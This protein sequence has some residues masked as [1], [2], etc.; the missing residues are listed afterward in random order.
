[1]TVTPTLHLMV[2]LPGVGKTTLASTI[3]EQS[4]ALRLTPDEWMQPLF[5]D[6]EA[7]GKRDVLEG[8][9]IWVAHRTLCGGLSV[10]LDFGFWSPEERYALRDIADRAGAQF[11]LHY[12][13]LS[14]EQRRSRAED[15]WRRG[16]TATFEMTAEDHDRFAEVFA[17]PTV[18]ELR[19]HTMP[20]PP[21]PFSS[22]PAWASWRWPSLPRVD[23]SQ[24]TEHVAVDGSGSASQV[25]GQQ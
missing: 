19:G 15:R 23:R 5:G 9:L 8:R 1:M 6:S 12:V 18:E 13:V 16:D 10:I 25:K 7:D 11:K 2:G 14:E 22:W 4:G 21:S 3:E 17:A 20:V 24:R